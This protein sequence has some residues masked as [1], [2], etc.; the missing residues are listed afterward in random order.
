MAT[1]D[2]HERLRFSQSDDVREGIARA[3]QQQFPGV[4]QVHSAHLRND[5]EGIDYLLEYPNGRI[6][7]VDVKVRDKDYERKGEPGLCIEVLSNVDTGKVGWALDESKQCDSIMFY[8]NDSGRS[9]SIPF[10]QLLVLVRHHKT[11]WLAKYGSVINLT[12]G[13]YGSRQRS[14]VFFMWT[15][16]MEVARYKTFCNAVKPALKRRSGVPNQLSA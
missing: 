10:D 7:T 15:W 5:L 2:F 6:R 16:D 1:Y 14:Q 3:I 8:W 9:Y 4:L 11:E 13:N 12:P